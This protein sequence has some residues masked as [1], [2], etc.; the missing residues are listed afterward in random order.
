MNA[1]TKELT[2]SLEI[3]SM[4][5]AEILGKFRRSNQMIEQ[6]TERLDEMLA[7]RMRLEAMNAAQAQEIVLLKE[8]LSHSNAKS[9]KRAHLSLVDNSKLSC[10]L[11][12]QAG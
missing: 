4:P 3:A 5:V 12:P 1:L 7:E 6:L 10:L 8:S 2:A 11:R 9:L